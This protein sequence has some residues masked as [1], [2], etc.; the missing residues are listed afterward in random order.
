MAKQYIHQENDELMMV[1][2]ETSA[3]PQGIT[4]PITLPTIGNYSVEYLKRELTDFAVKLLSRSQ[5]KSAVSHV[6]WRDLSVSDR[7]KSM[8]LGPAEMSNDTRSDKEL[9]AETLE[10]KYR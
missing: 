2:D 9:L 10:E 7:V 1:N 8:T 3:Y 6:S 5:S 4:I